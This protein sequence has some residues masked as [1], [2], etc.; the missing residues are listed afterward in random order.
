MM[1]GK[2]KEAER[3]RRRQPERRLLDEALAPQDAPPEPVD[4][5]HHRV[6]G[7]PEPVSFRDHI[8][9]EPH[10]GEVQPELHQ[11]RN[12]VSEVAVLHIQGREVDPHAEGGKEGKQQEEG[13]QEQI[14]T[15]REWE[16][17]GEDHDGVRGGSVGSMGSGPKNRAMEV[18]LSA[19]KEAYRASVRVPRKVL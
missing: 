6:E 1:E 11:E 10:R 5:P 15:R 18:E 4:H 16:H 9:G 19:Q 17:S 13:Q 8:R 2:A 3:D 14:P 12:D 7:I